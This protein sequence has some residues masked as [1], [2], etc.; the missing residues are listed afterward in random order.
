MKTKV[1]TKRYRRD[2][3]R[4]RRRG[5]DIEKIEEIIATLAQNS[6]LPEKTRDHLLTPSKHYI[7]GARECHIAPDLLLI[8]FLDKVMKKLHLIRVGRHSD[9]AMC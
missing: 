2:I 9:L 7:T 8:Y 3:E 1:E 4:E 5:T 6:R